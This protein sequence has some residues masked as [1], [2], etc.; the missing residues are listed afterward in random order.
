MKRIYMIAIV[1]L[2]LLLVGAF[3]ISPFSPLNKTTLNGEKVQLP[4]GFSVKNSTENSL[5]ISNGTTTFKLVSV[6][7]TDD[8]D[9]AR[10]MYKD[11]YGT[12]YNITEKKLNT[13]GGTAVIQDVAKL[14]NETA[15]RYWFVHKDKPYYVRTE[16]T[17]KNTE[18]IILNLIDSM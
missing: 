13:T 4:T 12:D 3:L 9:K 17:H 14:K 6:D 5:L 10:S 15:V 16:N 1:I 7:Y 18:E 11:K 2:L 8:L